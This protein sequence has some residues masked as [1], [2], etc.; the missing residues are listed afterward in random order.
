MDFYFLERGQAVR[1]IDFLTGYI[2]I[3]VKSTRKLVSADHTSNLGNFKNNY[4]VE[5]APLCKDDLVVLPRDLAHNLSDISPLVL[6]KAVGA[7]VHIIDPLTGEV[8][9]YATFY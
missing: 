7:G 6:V 4:M 2:P 1:F 5:I 3:R 8:R 9:K